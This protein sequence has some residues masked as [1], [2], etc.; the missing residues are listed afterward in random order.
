MVSVDLS[1]GLH[2]SVQMDWVT[3][4]PR[5]IQVY[6]LLRKSDTTKSIT[7]VQFIDNPILRKYPLESI[8]HL[9]CS[10]LYHH[11]FDHNHSYNLL[12]LH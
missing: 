11:N 6:T 10:I 9:D 5:N 8:D 2:G 7:L 1:N 4:P 12:R 3:L